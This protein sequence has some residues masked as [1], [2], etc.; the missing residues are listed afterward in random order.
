MA[1]TRLAGALG[2]RP[3]LLA[4]SRE[5]LVSLRKQLVPRQRLAR[6]LLIRGL[7]LLDV[8]H[9]L[10]AAERGERARG[11]LHRGKPGRQAEVLRRHRAREVT[12]TR[13]DVRAQVRLTLV[14]K[15]DGGEQ[16]NLLVP[17]LVDKVWKAFQAVEMCDHF[18]CVAL[19]DEELLALR[20]IEH[21]LRVLRHKRIEER[22]EAFVVSPLRTQDP[23]WSGKPMN[24]VR[25]NAC[26]RKTYPISGPLACESQ[27]ERISG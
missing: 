15:K 1:W 2:S 26:W 4:R 7:V 11:P 3:R 6:E 18:E 19:V 27:S 9:V 23:P 25:V 17:R 8:R 20:A 13:A 12:L 16:L 10:R 21:L 14:G 24:K 22:V 5:L